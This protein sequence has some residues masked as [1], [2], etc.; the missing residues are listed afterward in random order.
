MLENDDNKL[1]IIYERAVKYLHG[2]KPAEIT[3]KQFER[4]FQV[5]D[6]YKEKNKILERLCGTLQNYQSMPNVIGFYSKN[7]RAEGFKKIL[8]NFDDAKIL[9]VYRGYEELRDAFAKEFDIDKSNFERKNNS[10]AKYS[11]AVLSASKFMRQFKNAG[12]FNTFVGLFSYNEATRVALPL[13]LE[14]EIY[15]MGFALG[16]DFLKEIGYSQYPKPDVHL[17]GIFHALGL[18]ENNQLS[19]YKAII[20]M[21]KAVDE[22]PFKVDKVFWMIGSGNFD[23][24]DYKCKVESGKTGF[25]TNIKKD[26]KV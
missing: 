4:Y 15:G 6:V 9:D 25:V 1:K 18:C 21:A 5:H 13:L 24:G 8:F 20:R 11:N 12:D 10:W 17:I 19:C 26:L 7:E 2:M 23:S 14:R 16:C 22:T 3:D